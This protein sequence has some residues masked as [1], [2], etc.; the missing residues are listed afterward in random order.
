MGQ[1]A[2]VTVNL[3]AP[4]S[5]SHFGYWSLRNPQG[6]YFG[7]LVFPQVNVQTPSP[8]LTL[9]VDPPSPA[10]TGRVRIAAR[11]EAMPNFAAMRLLIN[12]AEVARTS[13]LDLYYTWDT[14]GYSAIGH[15]LVVEAVTWSDVG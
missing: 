7:P 14:A 4:A 2:D 1:S 5:G 13:G 6:E 8:Y 15:S 11:A 10:S 12:G 9:R 3:T